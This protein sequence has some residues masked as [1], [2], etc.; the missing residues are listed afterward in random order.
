M[1]LDIPGPSAA[2]E[3]QRAILP[4]AVEAPST[5]SPD[6]RANKGEK[7]SDAGS[8]SLLVKQSEL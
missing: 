5:L 6:S 4:A 8:L 1:A 2:E 7:G 3:Q